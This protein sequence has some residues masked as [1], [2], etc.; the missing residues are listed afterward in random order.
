M[1]NDKEIQRQK[2]LKYLGRAI[3]LVNKYL[4][5]PIDTGWTV[6]IHKRKSQTGTCDYFKKEIQISKYLLLHSNKFKE[7][8][9]TVLHEIAHALTM[10]DVHG[11][12]WKAKC[13]ELGCLPS[14]CTLPEVSKKLNDIQQSKYDYK[15]PNCGHIKKVN[16]RLKHI[17]AC[18]ICCRKYNDGKYTDKYKYE[19]WRRW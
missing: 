14:R 5:K 10:G 7:V 19:A 17:P 1:D 9:Q 16:R 12:K 13:V 8:Q 2:A 11:H 15:C 6:T 3:W 18:G 4:N